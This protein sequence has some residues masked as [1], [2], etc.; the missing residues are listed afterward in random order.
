MDDQGLFKVP[1]YV[2]EADLND[3]EVAKIVEKFGLDVVLHTLFGFDK[4]EVICEVEPY[5]YE[6][7]KCEHRQRMYPH[8]IVKAKRYS[9]IERLD[10]A[11]IKGA[12]ASDEAKLSAKNDKG[13]LSE[14]R[15]LGG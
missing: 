7:V 14:L 3:K 8:N 13:Y 6:V 5:F 9:G 10:K 1:V 2:S 4:N 12:M 11:W 15:K